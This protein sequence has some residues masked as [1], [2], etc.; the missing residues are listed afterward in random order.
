MGGSGKTVTAAALVFDKSVRAR[1]DVIAFLPFGQAPVLRDLQKTMHF[2]LVNKTLDGSLNG[3]EVLIALRMA[4]KD[5]KVLLVL[6]DVWTKEAY[7]PFVRVLDEATDSRL[8]VT[9][10]VKGL[11]PGAPEF[12]LGLLSADDS[13]SLLMECAGE[14]AGIPPHTELQYKAV[15]LCGHLPLVLSIGAC[16]VR[17]EEKR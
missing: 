7:Q 8:L 6:D 1:F 17:H 16:F 14:K 13:V 3:D 4:C 11:V 15:E 5:S 9:T 12:T 10:R 2:Q